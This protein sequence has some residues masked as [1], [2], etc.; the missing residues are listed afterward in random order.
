MSANNFKE[1]KTV[2]IHKNRLKEAEELQVGFISNPNSGKVMKKLG[3]K[4]CY[5]YEEQWMPKDI[6]VIFRMYQLNF[7]NS[8]Y[9]YDKYW[10]MYDKHFV[11]EI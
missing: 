9:V 6:K 11:E 7:D 8:E 10:N 4:Y 5:S 1:D 2:N 3:M